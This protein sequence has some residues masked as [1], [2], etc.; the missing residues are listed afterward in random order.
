[1]T[2]EQRKSRRV[3][4]THSDTVTVKLGRGYVDF[5]PGWTGAVVPDAFDFLTKNG[6]AEEV[7][8]DGEPPAPAVAGED[9]PTPE[10]SEFEQFEPE[11][12]AP[13]EEASEFEPYDEDQDDE[14][15]EGREDVGG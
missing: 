2:E 11:E 5:K 6:Y 1:M 10:F 4:I 7:Y 3:K 15:F 8:R 13:A 9:D 12:E 14:G